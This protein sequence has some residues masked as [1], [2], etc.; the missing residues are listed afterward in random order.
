[1]RMPLLLHCLVQQA[2]QILIEPAE[3]LLA[4]IDQRHLHAETMKDVGEFDPDR[5]APFDEDGFRQ[6][7]QVEGPI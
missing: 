4:T 3:D 1:M 6:L 2:A 5:A 7:R